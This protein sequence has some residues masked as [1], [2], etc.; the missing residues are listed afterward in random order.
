MKYICI[1]LLNSFSEK[2]Q[3]DFTNYL[4]P[5]ANNT[6]QK[7]YV[8]Y[9]QLKKYI[10]GK[11]EVNQQFEIRI[12]NAVFGKKKADKQ[13]TQIQKK[14][15]NNLM[16]TL[17]ALVENFLTIKQLND[18][19]AEKRAL[20][21]EALLEKKQFA[22]LKKRLHNDKKKLQLIKRKDA[23]Y[24]NQIRTIENFNFKTL[25]Q[26]GLI[27]KQ[28]NIEIINKN[29]DLYYILEKLSLKM[30]MLTV[31]QI[32]QRNFDYSSFASIE[33]YIKKQG[34]NTNA[35]IQAC[36]AMVHLLEQKTEKHYKH[37]L[38]LLNK[39]QNKIS[40]EILIGGYNIA[41][42]FCSYNLKRGI[43]S[44]QHTFDLH[45]IL[46][47]KNLLL[48]EDFMPVN[49]L[50]NLV[51]IAC[52]VNEFNWATKILNKYIT[53]TNKVFQKSVY[54]FNCGVIKF[55]EKKYNEALQN[56]IRVDDVNLAYDINYR[57]M[58]MKANYEVDEH[59]D[60]RTVQ[61]FRS[62]EKY[63]IANKLISNNNRTAYKNFV[64]MLINLYRIKHKVTKMKAGSFVKKLEAQKF[65]QD[66]S[67]LLAKLSKIEG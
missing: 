50:K 1:Y 59:Y 44:H 55:Y 25:H 64:R 4:I 56:F 65:N 22:L 16:S 67:W 6:S 9:Q 21:Y 32:T 23:D 12:F 41:V 20:L 51:A 17:T 66:K 10:I 29:L 26:T 57:I 62:A 35:A 33:H 27:T 7:I 42:N 18:K 53:Y 2:E 61:I 38:D 47:E 24:Y 58:M 63:F 36:L 54:E 13:L 3:A 52:R 30:S 45:Y 31:E 8:L 43:F 49:K 28:D 34:F 11:C 40:V 5:G 60:E 14:K 46:D 48:E 39:F 37:L 19:P 15:F